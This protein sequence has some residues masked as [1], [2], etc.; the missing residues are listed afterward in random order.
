MT[1]LA[2]ARRSK[3][4]LDWSPKQSANR[5]SKRQHAGLFSSAN[6]K[7][8]PAKTRGCYSYPKGPYYIT[9]IDKVARL[10]AISVDRRLPALAQCNG[11]ARHDGSIWRAGIL[12]RSI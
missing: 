1:H 4:R 5:L 12:A 9:N 8:R 3:V 10:T 7:D 6:V 2:C 11:K